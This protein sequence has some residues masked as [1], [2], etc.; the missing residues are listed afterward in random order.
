[1][2]NDKYLKE[3]LITYIG[4]KRSLLSFI[5]E[6]I[7]DI[8]SKLGKEK[9]TTFDGFAG[10][11]VVSRFLKQHSSKVYANDLEKYS[12]AIT[13]SFLTNKSEVDFDY[14]NQTVEHLNSVKNVSLGTGIIER[15]YAPRNTKDIQHGER[16]F[17]T[18]ENAKIIDRLRLEIENIVTDEKYKDIFLSI[19]L[20]KSSVHT[21]T[22]GV[23][24]GFYKSTETDTGKFGGNGENALERIMGE[25]VMEPIVLSNHEC[26]YQVFNGDT[27]E[28][29]KTMEE[30]DIVYYD[31]PYNQH[32]YGSN[33]H[34]L[35]TIYEN[36]EPEKISRVAGI[37]EDWN[38]S[39][40]NKKIEAEKAMDDLI[41]NT[42]AKYILVS[43]NNEGIIETNKMME[44]LQKYGEVELRTKLYNTYK[45]SRNLKEREQ[46]VQEQIYVLKK[47]NLKST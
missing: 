25:I 9:V 6:S 5:N 16:C 20:H 26:E 39:A 3:Q 30:V 32:P 14:I 37:R 12:Y 2:E 34:I 28:V 47:N 44:I 33:Y 31:P 38:K 24:K 42:K 11:G 40:Y 43:Y 35:N 8:K 45:G 17:Y 10:S 41:K 22:A 13:K 27:N 18:N 19:L 15:L 1:M 23:F 4:N 46:K 36:V 21:N 7:I 29:V